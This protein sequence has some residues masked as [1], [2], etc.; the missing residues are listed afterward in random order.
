VSAALAGRGPAR[1]RIR[2]DTVPEHDLTAA[3]TAVRRYLQY[4]ADPG[5]LRDDAAVEAAEKAV[6]EAGDPIEK[7]RALSALERAGRVDGT[8]LTRG[9]LLHA[10]AW[11]E[12]N[13][14]TVGAFQAL[15]VPDDVLAGAGF[16]VGRKANRK[17][18]RA[19]RE[20]DVVGDDSGRQRA[21]RTSRST[22]EEHITE[23]SGTFT[24]ADV[25][26]AVGGTP[27]TVSKVVSDLVALGTVRKLGPDPHHNSR[28]RAPILYERS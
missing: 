18:A 20:S 9:F 4:L 19:A 27:M 24:I 13:G 16:P 6:A 11:A 26:Q 23:R 22:I 2:L 10:R 12:A 8:H 3:E 7:L 14:I 28:G 5:S 15:G 21:P 25:L 17:P 1:R